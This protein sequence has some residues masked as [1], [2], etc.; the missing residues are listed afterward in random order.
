MVRTLASRASSVNKLA[1]DCDITRR[2]AYRDLQRI[3]GEDHPLTHTH[4]SGRKG[5]VIRHPG[6]PD[7]DGH[8]RIGGQ[9]PGAAACHCRSPLGR[10]EDLDR[11]RHVDWIITPLAGFGKT[12]Q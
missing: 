5:L 3:E 4:V 6:Q 11:N 8:P 12:I 9:T 2:Q 1:Q 10:R 7:G